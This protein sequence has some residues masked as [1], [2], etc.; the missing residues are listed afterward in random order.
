VIVILVMDRE[1]TE[2]LPR[3]LATASRTNPREDL[4][5]LLP[6]TLF[7]LLPVASDLSDDSIHCVFV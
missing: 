5:R 6:I 7:S 3:E 1:L 4:E 2:S